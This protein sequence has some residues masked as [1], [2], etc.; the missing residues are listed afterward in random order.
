MTVDCQPN[1]STEIAHVLEIARHWAS[2]EGFELD[3]GGFRFVRSEDALVVDLDSESESQFAAG[4][5]GELSRL[6]SLRSSSALAFNVFAPWKADPAPVAGILGGSGFY[7]RIAFERKYPTGVRTRRHPHLDVVIDAGEEI[8]AKPVPIA[9]ESKFCEIYDQPKPS[10]FSQ[11]Y[12]AKEDLWV[13]LPNLRVLAEDLAQNPLSFERLGAAQLVK[14]TLGLARA[15]EP[16]GFQL[17]YLWYDFEGDVARTHRA[18]LGRFVES[19][20]ADIAFQ[21]MTYQEL[22][23]ELADVPDPVP[24]YRRF[25]A[26]RYGLV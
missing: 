26:G 3:P 19:A 2:G 23:V 22:Y 15:H 6:G 9:I 24:G 18:E 17:I 7:D 5:G 1:E 20:G 16:A 21:A 12:L 11:N 13:G 10:Q 14:H 25:L 4:D 8:Q